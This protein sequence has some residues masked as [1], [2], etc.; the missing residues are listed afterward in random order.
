[1]T[2]KKTET[3]KNPAKKTQ[4]VTDST[5]NPIN[6]AN[7]ST[8]D[9]EKAIKER[10]AKEEAAQLKKKEEYEV[11]KHNLVVKLIYNAIQIED[12]LKR[13]KNDLHIA[14]DAQAERLAEYGEIRS[15]SKGGFSILDN[16]GEFKVTRIR[17]T[18]PTWD[19][20]SMKA[21]EL[22]KDFLSSTVKKHNRKLYEILISFIEKNANGDL[23]YQK[24]MNL[25]SHEDKYDDP[26][27]KEGLKLIKESYSVHLR[28]YGYEFARKNE[29]G[30]WDKINLSFSSM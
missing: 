3:K 23:E 11:M 2:T 22:I 7:V 19:E 15:N 18:Q 10:K 6:L 13:F 8:A 26:R 20:R 4:N 17:S 12:H 16:K 14:M 1:M 25:V 9:L 21:V 24:V 5:A 28:A 29:Q 27:W 30:G